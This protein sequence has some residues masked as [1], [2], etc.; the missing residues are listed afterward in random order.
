MNFK[1]LRELVN[2]NLKD[3]EIEAM[4][5]MAK[6]LPKDSVKTELKKKFPKVSKDDLDLV[7][8]LI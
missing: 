2:E 6:K 8:S 4:V 3:N 1:D 7:L 5:K